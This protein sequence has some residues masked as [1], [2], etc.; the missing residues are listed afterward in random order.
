MSANA[1]RIIVVGGGPV[2]M[3]AAH[4]LT[5]AGIDFVLLESRPEIVLNAGSNLVLSAMGLRALS[6]LGLLSAL[7][8]VSSPVTK[9]KRFDHKGRDLGDTWFFTFFQQRLVTALPNPPF[10]CLALMSSPAMVPI[11]ESSVAMTCSRSFG[12][13]FQPNPSRRYTQARRFRISKQQTTAS[14]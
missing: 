11:L 9:F 5:K 8:K 1:S 2:G 4:A 14:L 7:A 3:T 12:S 13:V 10:L 6:Q